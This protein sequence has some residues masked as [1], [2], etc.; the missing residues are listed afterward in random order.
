MSLTPGT[1]LGPYEILEPIGA[2]GMGEVYRARDAKLNRDVALKVLPES[3]AGDPDR[4]ARFRRE[5]QVLASLNHPN[6]AHIHGFEDSGT[7][8]ALVMEL[9][10]G[11]TLADRIAQRPIPIDEA[12][13]IAR[14]IAEA[15]EAAHDHGI[16]HRD[17]KPANIKVRPDGTV[18]VLD[19]GLAKATDAS[20]G[21]SSA[22][23]NSPTLSLHATETG[24]ILGTAAYMSP[25]QARGKV[26]DK[27]ADIWAFGVVLY[28]ML[29][30]RNLFAGETLSDTIAAVLTREFDWTA[31]PT[32]T[33]AGV[34]RVLARALEREP[35]R[36]L[37]DIGDARLELDQAASGSGDQVV[38]IVPRRSP[39]VRALIVLAVFAAGA[40]LA[41][42]IALVR[43]GQGPAQDA[44]PAM[45]F[46]RL[47]TQP[48]VSGT[49]SL[50]PD[51]KWLVYVSSAAGNED[52]YL[53]ATTGQT[54]INLTKDSPA[55]DST[56]VFSPDGDSIAFGSDRDGGG[57]FIMG[58]TGE[59]VRRLTQRGFQ[60]AWFPD[61]QQL[62]FTSEALGAVEIRAGAVSELWAVAAKGGE[63]H[64]LFAGDAMQPRVS[65]NGRR[66]AF[67]ALPVQGNSKQFSGANRDVWT[68][69]A[70]GSKPVRV[71]TDEATDW[72]PVWSPDGRWLHFL[73]NR[74][75]S[76]SLWR[77][78]IDD[79]TG[80]PSGAP[81]PLTL[82]AAY[83]RD[84]SLSADGRLGVYATLAVTSHVARVRFDLRTA[85]VQ[86]PFEPLTSGTR[87]FGSHDVSPDGRQVVVVTSQREQEDLYVMAGDGAGLRQLTNDAARDRWPRWSPDGRRIFFYSDRSGTFGLWSVDRDGSG[88][89]QLT[90]SGGRYYPTPSRDGSKLAASDINSWQIYVYDAHDF[91]KA[92]ELLPPLPEEMRRG[93]L[94]VVDWSPDGR[95]LR[96][97]TSAGQWV[98]SVDTR[99]FR[100]LPNTD[101]GRRPQWLPDGRRF[102]FTR[103]G[104]LWVADS[105]SG[106]EHEVFAIPGEGISALRLSA[107]GSYVY[108]SHGSASVDIWMVR[109]RRPDA[110]D[111]AVSLGALGGDSE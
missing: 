82:P 109:F 80:L 48:G 45:T 46:S 39:A 103:Q 105:V 57:I 84:F 89:R 20:A 86:G 106:N 44:I 92:P 36:R 60:P 52:V 98:Y 66:I 63:P 10:E 5:A 1:R 67:W 35:K 28:E 102:L 55:A 24:L 9:V 17:L 74:S 72:N 108:F 77:I 79:E 64:L 21:S 59:S 22:A 90:T 101:G 68:I 111:E 6:I 53:Q 58:R 73:S 91:S 11:P 30:G 54:S 26:V 96:G 12:L 93:A 37:R 32:E 16:I 100:R 95:L 69:A 65:P 27:R 31:L 3:L 15:L 97:S 76:M 34:R 70:D 110:G 81:Q 99:T 2:G 13:P 50:S 104:R 29:T 4:L 47:T 40:A 71:T 78:A 38:A 56:P 23:M 7:T 85:A 41:T 88:L 107:D 14:Q 94:N 49:P 8:H 51:G 87:E 83:S 18:K 43:R 61:G 62:V 33:P 19:F 75:G 25:E 42:G